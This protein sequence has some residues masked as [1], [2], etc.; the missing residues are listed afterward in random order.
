MPHRALIRKQRGRGYDLTFRSLRAGISACFTSHRA[1]SQY[2]VSWRLYFGWYTGR[3]ATQERRAVVDY[4]SNDLEAARNDNVL[5]SREVGFSDVPLYDTWR[6]PYYNTHR[7]D[8]S[9]PHEK[10]VDSSLICDLLHIYRYRLYS[11]VVVAAED[12][13][14]APAVVLA[15][16]WGAHPILLR[17][18]ARETKF[19]DLTGILRSWRT[20]Q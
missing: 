9:P 15:E 16:S 3:T 12:D 17:T 13:D 5:F 19:L 4:V 20:H 11:Q 7:T 2:T 18:N 8:F 1:T 6:A 10:M 14:F